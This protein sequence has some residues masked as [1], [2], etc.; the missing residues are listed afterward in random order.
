MTVESRR[1]FDR[2]G[3]R[4]TSLRGHAGKKALVNQATK[5]Q[6]KSFSAISTGIKQKSVDEVAKF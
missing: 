1:P 6:P 4:P 2:I 3:A 5:G